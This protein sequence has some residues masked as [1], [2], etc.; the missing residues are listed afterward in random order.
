MAELITVAH[1]A[2]N[3]SPRVTAPALNACA[4]WP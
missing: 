4:R 1:W 3:T 2:A